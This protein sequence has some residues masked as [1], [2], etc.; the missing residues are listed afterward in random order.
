VFELIQLPAFQAARHGALHDLMRGFPANPPATSHPACTL[1]H[2]SSTAAAKSARRNPSGC[3]AKPTTA[4]TPCRLRALFRSMLANRRVPRVL[5]PAHRSKAPWAIK[6]LFHPLP[7]AEFIHLLV[8][9][10]PGWETL[11]RLA[12]KPGTASGHLHGGKFR[13]T[14]PAFNRKVQ[15]AM[16]PLARLSYALFVLVFCLHRSQAAPVST[17]ESGFQ[18][19]IGL[20][21]GSRVIGKTP[22]A[23]L[24]FHSATFGDI[25]LAW[26]DIR[27]IK[28]PASSDTAEMTATNGDELTVTFSAKTL[29]VETSFGRTDL[30]VKLIRSLQVSALAKTGQLPPGL[31]SLWSGEGNAND[32]VGGNNGTLTGATTF[33]PGKIGQGFV[34]DGRS[35]SGVLLGNPASLQLQDFT[36]KAWIRRGSDAV[37]SYG[38]GGVGTIFG[39][40]WGGYCFYMGPDGELDFD[41][42]GDVAPQRGPSITDTNWHH[43]AVTKSG[44]EVVFYLDGTA[45]PV[46]SYTSTFMFTSPIGFGFRPD[47]QD[48][49]F[50]GT[51]DE[52]GFFNRA[53]SAAEIQAIYTEQ[54]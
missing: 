30:P 9:A 47:N 3:V 22:P 33:G 38:S 15:T 35:G 21:D 13:L 31:V 20:R 12:A 7:T 46:P 8:P 49:S 10:P 37:V 26:A 2:A 50:L 42:L 32:N 28:Y 39:C 51:L 19:T 44:S 36:I 18:L 16:K 45:C 24:G 41:R 6:S 40:G 52:T 29:R 43:V 17:N 4:S 1:A 34:F 27:F 48:N 23:T 14:V 11:A 5:G 25:K 54:Q 53:L